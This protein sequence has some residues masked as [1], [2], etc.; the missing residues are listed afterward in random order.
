[1][2]NFQHIIISYSKVKVSVS[3]CKF[4]L[5]N[6]ITVLVIY[7]QP[8]MKIGLLKHCTHTM[9]TYLEITIINGYQI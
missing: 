7:S 9:Y 2:K 4:T 3:N 6:L 8:T 5:E 1:M